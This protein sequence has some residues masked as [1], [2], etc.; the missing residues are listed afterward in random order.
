[1]SVGDQ[2]HNSV[3]PGA[4]QFATTHWSVVLS[5]SRKDSLSAAL[6]KLCRAYW[7]PLYVCVRRKGY[8]AHDAQ[9]LTQEFFSRL[10]DEFRAD[11]SAE[12]FDALQLFL[13]GDQRLIPY[14]EIGVRLRMTEGAV[15]VAAYRLRK[16]YGELLRDEIAQT[17]TTPEEAEDEIRYLIAVASR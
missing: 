3:P 4:G 14:A 9:D 6:E 11:R 5:A 12:L 15:K 7:Y 13:S 10:R 1:M 8:A 2:S 16:R 17:V